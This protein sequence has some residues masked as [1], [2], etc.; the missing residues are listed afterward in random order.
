MPQQKISTIFLALIFSVLLFSLFCD[1]QIPE[2][3]ELVQ[4]I[5]A[6]FYAADHGVN[7]NMSR[8]VFPHPTNYENRYY[9][10]RYIN[11]NDWQY[12]TDFRLRF[13]IKVTNTFDETVD[14]LEWIDVKLRLWSTNY[15]AISCTLSF[16]HHRTDSRQLVLHPG[17]SFHVYTEE[18]MEWDQTDENGQT[19]HNMNSYRPYSIRVD[20]VYKKVPLNQEQIYF[21]DTT[22]FAAVDTVVWFDPAIEMKAQADVKIFKN[23]D[24]IAS[25]IFNFKIIYFH[26]PGMIKRQR[27]PVVD[28]QLFGDEG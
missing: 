11:A 12:L 15:P 6:D 14:G 28:G 5:E 25:N 10:P 17:E 7:E 9:R 24:Y 4:V 26:P 19:I 27:C 8:T 2:G 22:Y 13:K 16:S 18:P 20:S 21:C 1:E 3:P 23:Y